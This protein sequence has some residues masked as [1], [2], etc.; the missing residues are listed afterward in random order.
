MKV[1]ILL[2]LILSIP[3]FAKCKVYGIS[4]SPQQ[5]NCELGDLKLKLSCNFNTYYINKDKVNLAFHMDVEE[6]A[7]PLVFKTKTGKTLIILPED[8][9]LAEYDD[10]KAYFEGTCTK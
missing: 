4:D 10:G 5:L 6:G 2:S 1:L 8:E 3:A 9:I 7:T